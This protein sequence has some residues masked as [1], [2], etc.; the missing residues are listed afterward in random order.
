MRRI[1][2]GWITVIAGLLITAVAAGMAINCFSLFVIPVSTDLGFSRAQMG[3][4]QTINALG[5]VVTSLISGW[6]FKKIE[7]KKIMKVSVAVIVIAYFTYSRLH[8]L[9][10]FYICAM[11]AS[12]SA[13]LL[14]WVPLAV[15]LNNW[16]V[17]RRAFAIGV[18]FM[19]SGIGG[20]VFSSV[21]SRLIESIGWRST[22]VVMAAVL[23]V[24]LVPIVFFILHVH[25]SEKGM[26]PYGDE[27]E[28]NEKHA[29]HNDDGVTVYEAAKDMRF[30]GILFLALVFGLA[31]NG[32][33]TTFVPHFEDQGYTRIRAG[34]IYS[35]Y[36]LTL[37]VGKMIMGS[38]FDRFG[39]KATTLTGISLMAVTLIGLIYCKVPAL[40]AVMLTCSGVGNCFPTVGLPVLA[41]AVYG[42][43][44]YAS[45]TG[46]LNTAGNIGSTISPTLLGLLRDVTG[47]YSFGYASFLALLFAGF[48]C[49]VFCV[50]RRKLEKR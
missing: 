31:T 24:V 37:A 46:I 8:R 12:M 28:D 9:W 49:A 36:M 22:F 33:T 50:P 6:L 47:T 20:M 48:I 41:R 42:K 32:F 45:F 3:V 39:A 10:M 30:Y 11:A 40:V 23:F 1:H 43:K 38:L 2:Y 34:E 18:S 27:G 16:F 17:K 29:E 14:T 21:G 7:L 15:I 25:P 13:S 26:R 4:C 5:F 35:V 44:E 19:G